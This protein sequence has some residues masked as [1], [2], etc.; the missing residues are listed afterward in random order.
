MDRKKRKLPKAALEQLISTAE[1]M[2]KEDKSR[3][4]KEIFKEYLRLIDKYGDYF[5]SEPWPKKFDIHRAITFTREDLDFIDENEDEFA[6]RIQT[7]I[8][9][10]N[11]SLKGYHSI[12]GTFWTRQAYYKQFI[13]PRLKPVSDAFEALVKT[14]IS[15]EEILAKLKEEFE[16]VEFIH[17][18]FLDFLDDHFLDA[19]VDLKASEV[20]ELIHTSEGFPE[21]EENRCKYQREKLKK[22]V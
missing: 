10:K 19:R 20:M 3:T 21:C 11:I 12:A 14:G 5:F 16:D 22:K 9:K 7:V 8:M 1:D 6:D 2:S 18:C 13:K 17:I 15:A 4:A